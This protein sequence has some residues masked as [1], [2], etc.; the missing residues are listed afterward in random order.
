M[1][2]ANRIP[3]LTGYDYNSCDQVDAAL[4]TV[5]SEVH[6]SN[7]NL[8]PSQ[9]ELL[10]WHFRL[11]HCG[12]KKIQFLFRSGVLSHSE[13]TRSLHAS[14]CK[15]FEMPRCAACLYG[16]QTLCPSLGLLK[17]KVRDKASMLKS[18]DLLPGQAVSVDHFVCSTKG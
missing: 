12:I 4:N 10:K 15:L 9:K 6:S 13:A 1:N 2:P 5:I 11:G 8:N 17:T 7:L 14:A 16:K 3:T 18:G